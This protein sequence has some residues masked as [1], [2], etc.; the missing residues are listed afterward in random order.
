MKK[1]LIYCGWLLL[2]GSVVFLDY[3][4]ITHKKTTSRALSTVNIG[5]APND[6]TGDPIRTAFGK[7]NLAIDA[8]NNGIDATTVFQPVAD[9]LTGKYATK[10]YVLTHTNG[11]T[12]WIDS[13]DVRSDPPA[14]GNVYINSGDKKIHYRVNGYWKRLQDKD[15]VTVSSYYGSEL[16]DNGAFAAVGDWVIESDQASIT[17]GGLVINGDA[18]NSIGYQAIAIS[19]GNTYKLEFDI[20]SYTSGSLFVYFGDSNYG[21]GYDIEFSGTQHVARNIVFNGTNT[22]PLHI[23]LMSSSIGFVGTIDNVSVMEVL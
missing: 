15:S 21:S 13:L 18:Y 4:A 2:I 17:G 9:S 7:V 1:I 11:G 6:H 16:V 14:S 12:S 22:P 19:Y 23:F 8:I 20:T 10:Y 3:K 5:S